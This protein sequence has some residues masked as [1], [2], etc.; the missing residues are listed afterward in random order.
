MT[1]RELHRE[2]VTQLE[3][4]ADHVTASKNTERAK[5]FNI[6]HTY[7][8]L[9]GE[10]LRDLIA[11]YEGQFSQLELT[12]RFHL[13]KMLYCSGISEQ[14]AFGD[15][16]L[17][18]SLDEISPSHFTYL[19]DITDCLSNWGDT[20]W[21]ASRITQPLLL[22][23]P[24]ETLSFLRNINSSTNMWK[25]RLSVVTFTR[26]VGESGRFTEDA[27]ELCN[28]LIWETED[29]VRKGVGWALKDTMRGA[30]T[31]VLDYVKSLRE[32][33]VSSV[34]TLYAIR[35]LKGRERKEVLAVK[36]GKARNSFEKG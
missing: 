25:R 8:G 19:E 20:D 4:R 17:V 12:E 11:Q 26:K 27:L 32:K 31:R 14:I 18:T 28:N 10:V 1:F 7:Y 34:I 36:P 2:I 3:K 30:R 6:N 9:T 29:L 33:G 35:D 15:T 21:F 5:R 22:K 23:Y 16:I 13:V 24:G